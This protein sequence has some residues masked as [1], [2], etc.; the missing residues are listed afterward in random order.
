VKVVMTADGDEKIREVGKGAFDPDFQFILDREHAIK[1]LRDV[2][3]YGQD[4]VPAETP[5]AWVVEAKNLLHAGKVRDVIRQV[6]STAELVEDEKNRAKVDNVATYFEE[7][8]SAV[9]Y[10][11]FKEQGWPQGSGAVEGGHI[12]FIP[13]SANG[14][15]AGSWT[16]STTPLPWLAFGKAAGG[17]SSGRQTQTHGIHRSSR[18][19]STDR[20][21][22]MGSVL[23]ADGRWPPVGTTDGHLWTGQRATT[24]RRGGRFRPHTI[25]VPSKCATSHRRGGRFRP[26][27]IRVPSKCAT[28]HR[29]G[30]RFRPHTIRVPSKCATSHRRGGRFL[31]HTIRV[32]SRPTPGARSC[33]AACRVID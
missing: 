1:H 26:H 2:P 15:L 11:Y 10:N 7:R 5:T 16:T 13:P 20:G 28:S 9:N 17:R 32:L 19:P 33:P 6:R 21:A 8:A 22:V 29:R 23:S 30:G 31:P 27:T 4:V 3:T 25:R 24:H 18:A 14:E 12:H